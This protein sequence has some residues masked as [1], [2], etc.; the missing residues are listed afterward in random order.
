MGEGS[1]QSWC[2][3]THHGFPIAT[4]ISREHN[5][6]RGDGGTCAFTLLRAQLSDNRTGRKIQRKLVQTELPDLSVARRGSCLQAAGLAQKGGDFFFA[7]LHRICTTERPKLC[8]FR[9]LLRFEFCWGAAVTTPRRAARRGEAERVE[10]SAGLFCH[11]GAGKSAGMSQKERPTFYRQELN[12]TVWE[13]P[14]RYQNL[15]PVGSG[16]YGSVW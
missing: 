15:S 6:Y 3:Q 7:Q 9:G 14:E 13:V 5:Y 4:Q 1:F 10:V 16:A 11:C 8:V 12:K 2:T